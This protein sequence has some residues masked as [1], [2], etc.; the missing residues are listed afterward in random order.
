[1]LKVFVDKQPAGNLFK[2]ELERGIFYFGYDTQC[3]SQNAVS[4]TMPV[5]S[6]PYPYDFKHQ[7][8][9]IFDM[10][11]PEGD[12][13]KHLRIQFSKAVPNFDDLAMLEILGKY[14]IGRLRFNSAGKDFIDVPAQS[15][16]ELIAHDG[17]EGLFDS[18]LDRYAVYSGIS[19][20]QPKVMLRNSD[21]SSVNRITHR[22]ATHIV[23]AW[24]PNEHPQL[25]ANEYFCMRAALHAKLEVPKFEL[26][27]NGKFLIVERFDLE[28]DSYLGFEDFCVLNGK[29]AEDKYKSTYENITRGIKEFVSP[30]L[31]RTALEE[32]FKSIT[33]SSAVMN[34]DAHL[35]NFGVLYA[36]TNATVRLSPAYDIVTTIPYIPG[37]SLALTLGGS[38]AW[39]KEKMLV[40][41][42]R[43]H[44]YITDAR[45][46][47]LMNE[48]AEGMVSASHEMVDYIKHNEFFKG[49][50][51]AMLVEWN[52]G[53][54]RSIMADGRPLYSTTK[55]RKE[56]NKDGQDVKQHVNSALA[57]VMPAN[58]CAKLGQIANGDGAKKENDDLEAE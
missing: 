20:V 51:E 18:L 19:G 52:K 8:H 40:K 15:L 28:N 41:F 37:D 50:G 32:F 2:S 14:Q 34:G 24:N 42:A 7:L 53:L 3:P 4:L 39:P 58:Q 9:P 11:L 43:Q 33:L 27:D 48:V 13:R 23:K 38:K 45:A 35:K 10:N 44:C 57:N 6:D 46:K 22:D 30:E 47:E 26:S 49:V 29:A 1:M 25:A 36:D 31:V 17:A 16:S 21:D 54:N 56:S 55:S 12:L 5:V